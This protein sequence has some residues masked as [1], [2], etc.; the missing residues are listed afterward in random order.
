MYSTVSTLKPEVTCQYEYFTEVVGEWFE[1][2]RTDRRDRSHNLTQL[3]L[4]EDGSFASRVQ[5]DHQDA[6]LL[7]APEAIKQLR[8]R[9]THLSGVLVSRGE[10]VSVV[11]E[12]RID[13][14]L[15]LYGQ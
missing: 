5:A 7:L 8:E 14:C 9:E 13:V 4:I 11:C 6:H 2:V 3:Q 12:Q 10:K 15:R 1:S